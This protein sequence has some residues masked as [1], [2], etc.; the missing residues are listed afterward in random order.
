MKELTPEMEKMVETLN[1][2]EATFPMAIVNWSDKEWKDYLI[3]A[4]QAVR[5]EAIEETEKAFGGCKKCYGKG[6]ST[7]IDFTYAAADFIGDKSS[8]TPNN[9]VRPCECER[10][11]TIRSL[12]PNNK[13]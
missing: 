13:E 10:G 1:D 3:K 9:P 2:I 6:Y 11:K 4:M 5:K 8:V 12:L 7:V